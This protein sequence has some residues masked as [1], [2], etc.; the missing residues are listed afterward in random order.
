MKL[1][2]VLNALPRGCYISS[3]RNDCWNAQDLIKY[4]QKYDETDKLHQEVITKDFDIFW[5]TGCSPPIH[6][7]SISQRVDYENC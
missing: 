1:I 7:Y 6:A 4:L 2:D 5:E 3:N